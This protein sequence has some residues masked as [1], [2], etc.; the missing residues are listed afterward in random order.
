MGG[1][2]QTAMH[3][4][5]PVNGMHPL[6]KSRAEPRAADR[7]LECL[8][9]LPIFEKRGPQGIVIWPQDFIAAVSQMELCKIDDRFAD[10][11]FAG[12]MFPPH[13]ANV[14][15]PRE[16]GP[17]VERLS[18]DQFEIRREP[19]WNASTVKRC[20]D[21]AVHRHFAPAPYTVELGC[22]RL[23]RG[24]FPERRLNA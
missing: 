11:A 14:L 12:Q 23:D 20:K 22:Q 19:G 5:R 24:L 1:K 9:E 2:I 10:L 6:S 4:H 13:Q 3:A 7:L 18:Q 16:L 8:Q 15:S 17:Q 21:R